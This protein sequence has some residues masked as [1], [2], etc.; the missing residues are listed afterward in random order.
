M[1]D[2]LVFEE[3]FETV[4]EEGEQFIDVCITRILGAIKVSPFTERTGEEFDLKVIPHH[5]PN[6][7]QCRAAECKGVL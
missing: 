4:V 2:A 1:A 5:Q 7:P 3:D 6:N